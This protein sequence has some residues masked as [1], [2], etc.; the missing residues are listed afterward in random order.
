[1]FPRQFGLHN[2]FTSTV[3]SMETAQRFK[4]YTM[5]EEEIRQHEGLGRRRELH[6]TVPKR[7]RGPLSELISKLQRL[8]TRCA[9]KQL[10]DYYCDVHNI[11]SAFCR[12]VI[13]KVIPDDFW[14]TG[15]TRQHNKH[16]ILRRV[17]Q[18][19]TRRRFE[20]LS[21]HEILQGFKVADVPWLAPPRMPPGNLSK[22]E[23]QKRIQLVAEFLYFLFD[24]FLIPLVRCNFYVTESSAY[25]NLL[26]YFRHDVWRLLSEPVLA[27]LKPSMFEEV[28]S[29]RAMRIL[30]TRAL[31]FSQI[32]LLPKAAGARLIMNLRR[33]TPTSRKGKMV[34]GRSINSVMG[35]VKSMLGYEGT[36]DPSRL[37]GAMFSVGD[38]YGKLR[39][40]KDRLLEAGQERQQLYFVKVDV[41]AC[42][43]SIPQAKIVKLVAELAS[44]EEYRIRRHV[45]IRPTPG[46]QRPAF[47]TQGVRALRRF[48]AQA[49]PLSDVRPFQQVVEQTLA[50]GKKN[51]VFVDQV[52]QASC[53]KD[54]L[55]ALL[56][57]H[58]Q[59]NIVKIGKKF[60][61]Q[62]AGIPQGSVLSS[63][64]CNF[65]YADFEASRLAFLQPTESLLLRLIDDFLLITTNRSH[66]ERF[67]QIMHRGDSDYGIS[68]SAEKTLA[69]FPWEVDGVGIP[70]LKGSQFFPFC[71]SFI[72]ARTLE[73]SKDRTRRRESA[74]AMFLDSSFNSTFTVLSN[75]HQNFIETAMKYYRYAKSLPTSKQPGDALLISTSPRPRSSCCLC[76]S[77]Q[78]RD[79]R[80]KRGPSA[81][82]MPYAPKTAETISD[83]VELAFMLIKSRAK[84]DK[85]PTFRCGV[86]KTQIQWL[87]F[88]A[89]HLVLCRK[90]SRY[91]AVLA[92]L[93][94]S[95]A[96]AS[97]AHAKGKAGAERARLLRVV[98]AGQQ[99]FRGCRY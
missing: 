98:R 90:Q 85:H 69:N 49:R 23:H 70:V 60:Y 96:V 28:E 7:L 22:M 77:S 67:L 65:F 46:H 97:A 15:N 36:S 12:A 50:P 99:A 71:G 41:R 9:Y 2:V 3:D 89:F 59:R 30:D 72:H 16:A 17:D 35:P 19:I 66:A 82:H 75:I 4:D 52:V 91:Q 93:D 27:S 43:D 61:R 40:F 13:G 21:L 86:T 64:L 14:G 83:V 57:E 31:G 18:F 26:F 73:I 34:L 53:S 56:V 37:G 33:R 47:A 44:Q 92:W 58:I 95:I 88:S 62:K 11:V 42:F 79:E 74:H 81:N 45:E 1:M 24:S 51:L 87:A 63:S 25:G 48:V 38:M 29:S 32:R 5:R 84:Q 94:R 55:L 80:E 39:V 76:A 8:H 20:S 6:Q 68:V 54:D 78:R 10:L